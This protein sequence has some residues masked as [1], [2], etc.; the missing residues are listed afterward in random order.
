M[1]FCIPTETDRGLDAPVA[2]HFGHAAW[3]TVVDTARGTV[4]V[5]ANPGC[6]SH[7]GACHHVGLLRDLGVEA[8]AGVRIGRRATQ[9]LRDTGIEVYGSTAPRVREIIAALNTADATPVDLASTCEGHG[10]HHGGRGHGDRH[11]G[12]R[13]QGLRR[14]HRQREG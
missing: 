10:P 5:R 8:V 12:G 13:G 6:H 2:E 9:A 11:G 4:A 7:A 1:K 14:R 3:F